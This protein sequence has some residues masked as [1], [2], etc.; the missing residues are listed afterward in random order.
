MANFKELINQD[1]PVLVDFFA[2]WCGP[3]KAIAPAFEAGL[4]QMPMNIQPIIMDADESF[5]MYAFMKRK[6]RINGVPAF[7]CYYKTNRDFANYIPDDSCLG[8][9]VGELNLFFERC[10]NY[11]N[12][13]IA[14]G[15]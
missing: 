5:E 8:S 12:Q 4:K 13:L 10:F 11:A 1:K 2:T 9:D 7:L 3:C 6:R 14:T 15:K